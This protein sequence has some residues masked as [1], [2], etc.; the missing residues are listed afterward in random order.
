MSA[1]SSS[2]ASARRRTEAFSTLAWTYTVITHV[3]GRDPDFLK[4]AEDLAKLLQ[5]ATALV[6][7]L[8]GGNARIG[9]RVRE[10]FHDAHHLVADV[11]SDV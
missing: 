10:G 8:V 9:V 5:R 2:R 3:V 1:S 11:L 6:H 4:R 7:Q